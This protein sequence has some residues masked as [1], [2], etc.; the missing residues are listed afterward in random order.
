MNWNEARVAYT[1]YQKD[2]AAPGDRR[3]FVFYATERNIKFQ[4]AE[5]SKL[6]DIVYL[7]YG[8]D[9]SAWIEYKVLHPEVKI[10]FELIDSYLFEDQSLLTIF[11]GITRYLLG[12]ESSL[13]FNYKSALR[14]IVSIADAVVCSTNA[15][16][17]DMLRFNS[18]IHVSLDY[19]SN[20]ITS[21]KTSLKSSKRL[22][23]VWEGQAYTVKNLLLLNEVFEK[24][25]D[26]VE[27][28]IVTDPIIKSPFRFLNRK[29]N[30]LLKKLK[31]QYHLI[32]WDKNSF[33]ELISN[34]DLAIIPIE[35][36]N[37]M[38]WNK[39][40]NKLLLLWEIGVPTLT[41]ATP[42]Y[43]RV[44]NCADLDF[45]CTS[46]KEWLQ[47]IEEYRCSSLEYKFE[48]YKKYK[49]YLNRFHSK[50]T[51]LRSWDQIFE[52]LEVGHERI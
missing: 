28:Y 7:T 20:D 10:I 12:K 47:K 13:W 24:L 33:S 4:L 34:A 8:C 37:M 38:M 45:L 31:C 43:M 39:P 27:L 42:A 30:S 51:I 40:E 48:I 14:K 6:Y 22:R 2:L 11:R 17:L 9:L 5:P 49:S 44:M 46:S 26:E 21:Y 23:L 25:G 50:G 32:Y 41:S 29:T 1:P 16:K 36:N 35:S 3:R 19:F 18:N 15:Q 52:S